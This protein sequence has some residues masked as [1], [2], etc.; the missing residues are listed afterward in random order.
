MRYQTCPTPIGTLTLHGDDEHLLHL[1]F[2]GRGPTDAEPSPQNLPLDLAA[3]QLHEYFTGERR[4]FELPL[5]PAGTAFQQRVWQL[6][7]EIPYGQ[8]TTYGEIARALSAERGDG[9]QRIEPRAVAGCVART[10]IPI[11]IPCHRVIGADGSLRGYGGG[12]DRK[13]KLLD[14]ESSGGDPRALDQR[15]PDRQLTML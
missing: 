5:A 8:T 14:F 15:W 1:Y 9:H 2:P 12:L 4:R 3:H 6:L 11:I 10:P 7:Q 13:R